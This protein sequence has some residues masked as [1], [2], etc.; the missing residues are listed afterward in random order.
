MIPVLE[1]EAVLEVPFEP[2]PH[3]RDRAFKVVG[4]LDGAPAPI[5]ERLGRAA[6]GALLIWGAYTLQAS[7]QLPTH[8][9][10]VPLSLGLYAC[11][12]FALI[13]AAVSSPLSA[14]RRQAITWVITTA[15]LGRVA[16]NA[17]ASIAIQNPRYGT[18]GI[19]LG[20]MAVEHVLAGINPYTITVDGS[21]LRAL[22]V[23]LNSLT[24]TTSGEFIPNSL[25]YPALSFLDFVPF[26]AAGLHD[27][28]WT[29]LLFELASL[30]VV[31]AAVPW[32]VRL[33]ALIAIVADINLSI[34][35]VSGSVV[36][37]IW[38][39]PLLLM[40]VSIKRGKWTTAAV[41]L[42]IAA[43][44][45]QQSW[46]LIPFLAV[47]L[48]TYLSGSVQP[49]KRMVKFFSIAFGVFLLPNIPFLLL[50]GHAWYVSVIAPLF[51]PPDGQG[52][53]ILG[54]FSMIRMSEAT[55]SAIF[56]GAGVILF[57]GYVLY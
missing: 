28:R 29:V 5:E 55:Y 3:T 35:F 9:Y 16:L 38:V 10:L 22:G 20:Q 36:D 24:Q 30:I 21:E 52:L 19:A 42:G 12:F 11:G 39:L 40:L 51:Q 49:I 50:N 48:Y 32:K 56:A 33:W 7:A 54:Q 44:T 17:Y 45:K 6:A 37:W 47:W 31:V 27:L 41:F 14:F 23:P 53:S 25:S 46:F 2:S 8:T 4:K 15:I 18:D 34:Y 1:P 57:A 26:F 43:A 13:S